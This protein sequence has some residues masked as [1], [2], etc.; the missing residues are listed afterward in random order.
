MN[1]PKV[2]AIMNMAGES[3]DAAMKPLLGVEPGQVAIYRIYAVVATGPGQWVDCCMAA[4]AGQVNNPVGME[5]MLKMLDRAEEG[6]RQQMA[7][8]LVPTAGGRN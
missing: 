3:M 8:Q 6:R 1:D 2:D 4:G 7:A 5:F